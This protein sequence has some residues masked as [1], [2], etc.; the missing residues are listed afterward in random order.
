[1][2]EAMARGTIDQNKFPPNDPRG[3]RM[4]ARMAAELGADLVKTY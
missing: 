4:A 1:M 3:I 2:V